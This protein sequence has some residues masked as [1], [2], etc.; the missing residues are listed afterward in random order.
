M[1]C[2]LGSHYRPSGQSRKTKLQIDDWDNHAQ[3]AFDSQREFGDVSC[4]LCKLTLD[5]TESI[6]AETNTLCSPLFSRCANFICAGCTGNGASR[7]VELSCGHTPQCPMARVSV[8]DSAN[9][10]GLASGA[11]LHPEALPT[12]ILAL[13]AEVK[14][15]E[16]DVKW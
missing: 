7:L 5:A 2:N 6:I 3:Q 13:V 8:N 1:I 4:C 16:K 12:K 15:L 9:Q 11:L 14:A 10:V